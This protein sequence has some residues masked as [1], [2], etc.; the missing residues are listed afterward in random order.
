[1][2][3]ATLHRETLVVELHSDVPIDV[4]V[5]RRQGERQV[6]LRRH[7]PRWRAGGVKAS[8]LTVGG[9]QESQRI[10]DPADP[11]RSA[12]LTVEDDG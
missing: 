4:V 10:H 6:L 3:A 7:L 2:D 9:D 5:R 1:M 12:L 11:F 8:V